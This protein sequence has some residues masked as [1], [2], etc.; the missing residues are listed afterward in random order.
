MDAFVVIACPENDIFDSKD[1][2]KPML[3]PFEVELAFNNSRKFSTNY[4]LDFRQLLPGGF[5]YVEFKPTDDSDVSMLSNEI[6][7]T[8]K[9]NCTIDK[10]DTVACK[11]DGTV[12]IGKSGAN[13]LL[14]RS[15][16][17]L[18]QKL[19]ENT[20][21]VATKGRSGLP[22]SYDN[23]PVKNNNQLTENKSF[24]S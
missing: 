5:N 4:C 23:E 18:E 8:N 16:Q 2:Y 12:A 15:W 9:V 20:I 6:R 17:G 13:F 7:N 14:N 22:I 24:I 10:M 1:Y 3:T 21:E 11:A 19:G